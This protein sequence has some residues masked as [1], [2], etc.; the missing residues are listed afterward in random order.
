[1]LNEYLD[2]ER[3]EDELTKVSSK[4]FNVI[5]FFFFFFFFVFSTENNAYSFGRTTIA[6]LDAE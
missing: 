4:G 1:M 6:N 2:F 5:D 3:F